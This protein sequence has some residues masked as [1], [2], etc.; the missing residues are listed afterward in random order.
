MLNFTGISTDNE[1]EISVKVTSEHACYEFSYNPLMRYLENNAYLF[2][3]VLIVIGIT[4]GLFGKPLFKPSICLVGTIVFT[5]VTSLFIFSEL[6]SRDTTPLT[7]WI[8][9][10]ICACIGVLVGIVLAFLTRAGVAVLAGWGGFCVGLILYNSFIYKFDND[11]KAAFWA[12]TIGLAII[13]GLLSF[14]LLWHAIIIASSVAGS[15]AIMKGVS[16][17]TGGFPD[18]M[19]LYYMIKMGK[20]EG[21]N[22]AF[23][24]FFV[25]FILVSILFI[26]F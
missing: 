21:V 6:F 15:Y 24:I 7:A 19:E 12:S 4:I 11:G 16:M 14:W 5:L 8:V 2:G 22:P 18:E 23:Y 20:L 17:Y 3:A 13:A 25:F 9:F 26:V 10:I 1:C